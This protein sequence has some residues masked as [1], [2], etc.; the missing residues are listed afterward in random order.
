MRV[1]RRL[2]GVRYGIH[3]FVVLGLLW[4][5]VGASTTTTS[6]ADMSITIQNFA[7]D[8]AT[9]TIPVG[10]KVKWTNKDAAPHTATSDTGAFDSKNLTTGQSFSFTFNQAGS[11][12]Y[13]CSV[14]PRM[15]ATIV[16]TAGGGAATTANAPSA[17]TASPS[18]VLPQT[19]AAQDSRNR[20]LI[21]ALVVAAAVIA[22]GMTL[23]LRTS[24]QRKN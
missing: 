6:A 18:S 20:N 14:H 12:A 9:I 8:P 7:F 17:S 5:I 4:L 13:H 24:N 3:L 1:R 16:V 15:V 22:A 2:P 23:R 21:I 19:G 10:T 11:F